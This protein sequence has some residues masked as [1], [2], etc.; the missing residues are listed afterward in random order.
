MNDMY[1]A[2]SPHRQSRQQNQWLSSGW[3]GSAAVGTAGSYGLEVCHELLTGG[4]SQPAQ[5]PSGE[6][7]AELLLH[8]AAVELHPQVKAWRYVSARKTGC[9]ETQLYYFTLVTEI[10]HTTVQKCFFYVSEKKYRVLSKAAFIWLKKLYCQI[11]IAIYFYF[12][13]FYCL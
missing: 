6:A 5:P 13:Y 7:H 9:M 1:T 3:S 11:N 8:T 4:T 2:P 10:L 12:V